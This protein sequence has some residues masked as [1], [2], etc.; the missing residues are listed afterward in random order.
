[1]YAF[2]V[3]KIIKGDKMKRLENET[4]DEYKERR[5]KENKILKIRKKGCY[6]WQSDTQGTRVGKFKNKESYIYNDKFNPEN[7]LKEKIDEKEETNA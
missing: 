6:L 2:R 5:N 7:F 1:L 4:Y 3:Q